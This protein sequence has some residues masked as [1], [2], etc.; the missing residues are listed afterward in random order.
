MDCGSN[1]NNGWENNNILKMNITPK[2]EIRLGYR[3]EF[4]RSGDMSDTPLF[5]SPNFTMKGLL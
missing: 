4:L 1:K 5:Y 2:K 3:P